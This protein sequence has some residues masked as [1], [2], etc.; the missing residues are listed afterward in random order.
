MWRLAFVK[1]VFLGDSKKETNYGYPLAGQNMEAATALSPLKS[2][3]SQS[4]TKD[5]LQAQ[6]TTH[7]TQPDNH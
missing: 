5:G 6:P 2:C 7:D 1:L 3:R 4:T